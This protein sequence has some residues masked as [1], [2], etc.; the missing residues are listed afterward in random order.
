[1]NSLTNAQRENDELEI[2]TQW[3]WSN[4]ERQRPMKS[5]DQWVGWQRKK[6][7]NEKPD[8]IDRWNMKDRINSRT[9][10]DSRIIMVRGRKRKQTIVENRIMTGNI[11]IRCLTS[12][13]P[14][15]FTCLVFY[16]LNRWLV[17]ILAFWRVGWLAGWQLIYWLICAMRVDLQE[18][19]LQTCKERLEQ[20]RKTETRRERERPKDCETHTQKQKDRER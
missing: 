19:E 18:E 11:T 8:V 14:D 2:S 9:N 12:W 17:C 1:M 4:E 15:W 5:S 10:R 13:L 20:K 6:N 7:N 3:K 16:L